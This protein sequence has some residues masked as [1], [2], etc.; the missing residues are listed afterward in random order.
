MNWN[1]VGWMRRLHW[2]LGILGAALGFIWRP[3]KRQ[4]RFWWRHI[5][6]SYFVARTEQKTPADIPA[7]IVLLWPV[8]TVATTV[9]AISQYCRGFWVRFAPWVQVGQSPVSIQG[10]SMWDLWWIRWQWDRFFS[11]YFGCP[12]SVPFHLCSALLFIYMLLLNQKDERGEAWEPTVRCVD[13]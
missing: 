8:C 2:Q 10:Q 5:P 11:E 4:E 7:F 1:S 9:K 13:K 6:G 3:R 12:L